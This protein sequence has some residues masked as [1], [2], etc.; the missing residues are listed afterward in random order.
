M[1]K[2]KGIFV[3]AECWACIPLSMVLNLPLNPALGHCPSLSLALSLALIPELALRLAT[4][5]T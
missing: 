4:P 3:E 2:L 5:A 1:L